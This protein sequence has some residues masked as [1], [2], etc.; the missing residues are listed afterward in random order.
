ML[1]KKV[2]LGIDVGTTNL[3]LVLCTGQNQV[4]YQISMPLNAKVVHRPAGFSEQAPE[5]F[6]IAL[7][8]AMLKLRSDPASLAALSRLDSIGICGQ[9]HGIM[10]WEAKDPTSHSTL[11]TWEDRRCSPHFLASVE[12]QTGYRLSSGMG[13]ATMIWFQQN[14]SHALENYDCFGTIADYLAYVLVDYE[15]TRTLMMD[16]TNAESFGFFNASERCWDV[17]A[18][19]KCCTNFHILF[20]TVVKSTTVFGH[21]SDRLI[22]RWKFPRKVP[23]NVAVGDA[24]ATYFALA[25]D[26]NAMTTAVLN[27][28]TSAQLSFSV[29]EQMLSKPSKSFTV[30]P[31]FSD[32]WLGVAASLNG[33]N[34]LAQTLSNIH[35]IIVSSGCQV[36]GGNELLENMNKAAISC[37]HERNCTLQCNPRFYGERDAPKDSGSYSGIS[38]SNFNLGEIYWSTVLNL[39]KNLKRLAPREKV[40]KLKRIVGVGG[41]FKA[42]KALRVAMR[43]VF[44]HC[45]IDFADSTAQAA[46]G[47]A[48]LSLI[49]LAERKKESFESLQTEEKEKKNAVK[50][51]IAEVKKKT[52][53]GGI[54]YYGKELNNRNGNGNY[55]D[56]DRTELT[57]SQ[58]RLQAYRRRNGRKSGVYVPP[59][60]TNSKYLEVQMPSKR[61][62]E[63]GVKPYN[64]IK[65]KTRHPVWSIDDTLMPRRENRSIES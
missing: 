17:A 46:V 26:D 3:K 10:F 23:V 56:N 9:M 38:S 40:Q 32:G 47:A 39:L 42:N 33:G 29:K 44:P 50:K 49:T 18:V 55:D 12:R 48:M 27:V 45:R 65:L 2:C 59:L 60:R 61:H 54:L 31:F 64:G 57:R 11:V 19:K 15:K 36:P 7:D 6:L 20:P 16:E 51:T 25:R 62:Q 58:K 4:I 5:N 1:K 34:V 37:F 22:K 8:K 53:P 41:A 30:R 14:D 28:G 35:G 21:T 43:E 24:A 52:L 13:F 63:S